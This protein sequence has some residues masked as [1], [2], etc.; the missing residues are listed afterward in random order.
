MTA[1]DGLVDA[2]CV[3]AGGGE[4]CRDARAEVLELAARL[5]APVGFTFFKPA[6]VEGGKLSGMDFHAGHNGAPVLNDAI[7][8]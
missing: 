6:K 5:K 7:A 8:I 2:A 1:S 3:L 4:G